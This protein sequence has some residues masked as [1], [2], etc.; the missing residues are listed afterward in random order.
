MKGSRSEFLA[1]MKKMSKKGF[2]EVLEHVK[3]NPDVHYNDVLRYAFDRKIID[4]RASVTIILNG[5]TDI[6]LLERSVSDTRPIRT[7]YRL[8]KKGET[9]LK[10]ISI[11]ESIVSK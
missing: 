8:S 3:E 11:L 5:L 9:V 4:S 10:Q 1:F 7:T 6:G 2:Y